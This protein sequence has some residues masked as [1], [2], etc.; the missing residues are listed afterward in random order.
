MLRSRFEAIGTYIEVVLHGQAAALGTAVR[1]LRTELAALDLAC[2]RFRPDSELVRL[3]AA[4]GRWVEVSPLLADLIA[5]ALLAAEQTGGDVDPALADSLV[6]A[7]YDRDFAALPADGTTVRPR[8]PRRGAWHD[9]ELDAAAGRVRLPTG[10]ALDLGATAKASAADRAAGRIAA[11]TDAGV[12]VNLGGDIALAGPVLPGG[13]PVRVTDHAAHDE[14]GSGQVVHLHGG[15]LAT[16]STAVRRWRRGGSPYHHILDPRT[17][18]PAA[19][20]WRTVSVAAATCVDAN[21]ASTASIVRGRSAVY[22]LAGLGLPARLVETGGPVHRTAGW[23]GEHP[24]V[25]RSHRTDRGGGRVVAGS[26]AGAGVAESREALLTAVGRPFGARV[27][28][29]RGVVGLATLPVAE[30]CRP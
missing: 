10:A 21:T 6:A 29:V 16:S 19:P 1:L 11:A 14:S 8:P 26:T 2:S 25:V 24:A 18:L 9:I 27:R 17:G 23:P 28:P 22:W 15:G 12:L 5:T 20:V 30:D 3:N 13:W 7:G 4:A